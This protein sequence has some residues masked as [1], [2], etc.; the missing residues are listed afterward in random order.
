[1]RLL[2]VHLTLVLVYLV[3]TES[4][5]RGSVA[6]GVLL[7][8]LALGAAGPLYRGTN[9]LMRWLQLGRFVVD[10]VFELVVSSLVVAREAVSLKRRLTSGFVI[11]PLRARTDLEIT[12]LTN[13]ITLTPGTLAVALSPGA[14]ELC[15]HVLAR[16][17]L[18]SRR[19]IIERLE[20]R[21]LE[22]VRG[23]PLGSVAEEDGS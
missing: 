14:R 6:V 7:G 15:V 19:A 5:D 2:G 13:L 8:A 10:Y 12:L 20:P 4:A 21:I 22:L 11:V 23:Q 9:Y 16:D 18:E 17:P 3:L 1:M